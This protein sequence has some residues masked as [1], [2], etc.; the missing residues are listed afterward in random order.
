MRPDRAHWSHCLWRR[1]ETIKYYLTIPHQYRRWE[2]PQVSF[3][4]RQKFCHYMHVCRNKTWLLSWQKY[5]CCDKTCYD[6]HIFSDKHNFVMTKHVFCCKKSMLVLTKLLSRQ[7]RVCC[8]KYLWQQKF[9][10]DKHTFV[11][12][13]MILVAA[14]AQ[15]YTK[16]ASMIVS[17]KL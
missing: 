15:W 5:A 13:K 12:T 7:T 14:P 11:A 9:C 16:L 17:T 6:K 2:L 1:R 4:S 3:L 8:D 10:H